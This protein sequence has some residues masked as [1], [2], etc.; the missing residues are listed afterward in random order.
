MHVSIF[1]RNFVAVM[2]RRILLFISLLLLVLSARA[3]FVTLRTGKTIEGTILVHNEEVLIIRDHNGQRH[4]YPAT[5]ILSVSATAAKQDKK[6]DEPQKSAAAETEK[7]H[8]QGGK[9]TSLL[10]EIAGGAATEPQ[11]RWGGGITGNILIGTRSIAGREIILGGMVGYHGCFLPAQESPKQTLNFIPI[12]IAMRLPITSHTHAP[13]IGA[14]LGY[15]I[16]V[17]KDYV[18]GIYTGLDL[19]YRYKHKSGKNIYAGANIQFQQAR[20]RATEI[21]EENIYQG[22]MG[23]NL[24]T[25]GAKIA[26]QL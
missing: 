1:F 24:V 25:I 10:V 22:K 5:E 15:G 6:A 23:C 13:Y 17:S 20:I 8:K 4:Q 18:G 21:I 9:K 12:A 26:L 19:G 7:T 14:S 3:E 16:A 11:K 2:H